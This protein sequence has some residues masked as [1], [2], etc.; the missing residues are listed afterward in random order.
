MLVLFQ[1]TPTPTWWSAPSWKGLLRMKP[2]ETEVWMKAK[3]PV[4]VLKRP[5]RLW[6]IRNSRLGR[7]P[8]SIERSALKISS[9][10][11][12]T[13]IATQG[14]GDL[15]QLYLIALRDGVDYHVTFIPPRFEEKT[16]LPFDRAYMNALYRFGR[17]YALSG[18]AWSNVPPGYSSRSLLPE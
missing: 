16:D 1:A 17:E 6:V 4:A 8:E 15:Y 5:R 2:P 14:V 9:R 18:A 13:L 3:L 11:L 10:A 12:A 7:R